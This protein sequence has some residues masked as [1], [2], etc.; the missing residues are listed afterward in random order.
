[1]K[2]GNKMVIFFLKKEYIIIIKNVVMQKAQIE[3]DPTKLKI[4]V[5]TAHVGFTLSFSAMEND[6]CS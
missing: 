6:T 3:I 4:K 2:A 1:M 5:T